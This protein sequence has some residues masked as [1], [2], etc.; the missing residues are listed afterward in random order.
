M[1]EEMIQKITEIEAIPEKRAKGREAV[2]NH[3]LRRAGQ[4]A[5]IELLDRVGASPAKAV[6]INEEELA[7]WPDEAVAALK[8]Q[9]MLVRAKPATSTICPGCEH[10]C[11][12][13]VHIIPTKE[14]WPARVFIFCDKRSDIS[15]VTVSLMKLNQWRCT[16]DY[17]CRFIA[18]CLELRRSN[19]LSD[20]SNLSN[21]GIAKGKKRHQMLCL[22]DDGIL[23]LVAGNS[24]LPLNELIEFRDGAYSL[25]ETMIRQLV[26]SATVTE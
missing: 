19:Q 12:M 4:S 24:R 16:T 3:I 17:V 5:L 15:R 21:I 22:E 8:T 1:N 11:V 20:N 10:E 25:D 9:K 2:H 13:P 6:F 18:T 23:S 7:Y 14:H 26:D